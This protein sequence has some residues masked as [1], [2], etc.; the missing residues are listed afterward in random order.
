M[1]DDERELAAV[2]QLMREVL[3]RVEPIPERALRAAYQARQMRSLEAELATLLYDSERDGDLL[4]TRSS[5]AEVR[6]LSLANDHLS[7]E[8]SLLPDGETI[9]GELS[10][11]DDTRQVLVETRDSDDATAVEVDQF[12]RFRATVVG[13]IRIR[14]PG[15]LVTPW[16]T[17]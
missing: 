5:E 8:L 11:V 9:V 7:V 16:I 2:E 12:G 14:V 10:P 3:D 4:L 6:L 1:P 17:R 13:P 15:K